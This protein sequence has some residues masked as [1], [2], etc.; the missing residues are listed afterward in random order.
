MSNILRIRNVVTGAFSQI[1]KKFGGLKATKL[2][3]F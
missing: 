2:M 3:A 1:A